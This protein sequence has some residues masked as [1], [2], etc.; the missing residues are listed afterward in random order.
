MSGC[1]KCRGREEAGWLCA[2]PAS[3]GTE[4]PFSEAE[5]QILQHLYYSRANN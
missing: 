1:L 4:F 2:F 3:P 5:S